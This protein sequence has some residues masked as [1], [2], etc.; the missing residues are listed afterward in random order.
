MA[1]K[2]LDEKRV[3]DGMKPIAACV[4]HIPLSAKLGLGTDNMS[5]INLTYTLWL[6]ELLDFNEDSSKKYPILK[7]RI[8][9]SGVKS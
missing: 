3:E 9:F 4:R 7:L 8:I 6:A 2:I 1:V 5:N